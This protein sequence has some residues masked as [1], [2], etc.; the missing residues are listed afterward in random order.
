MAL[1]LGR[2]FVITKGGGH[3]ATGALTMATARPYV[4]RMDLSPEELTFVR[5]LVKTSRQRI[6]LVKWV[7]RDGT[8]RQTML[9]Q[10]EA[11]RLNAVAHRLAV[12]KGE[13]LRQ[14]AHIPNAK[15]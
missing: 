13:V 4:L 11:V 1:R 5:E 7:D 12:S 2:A 9:T 10:T 8:D 15:Q 6:H 3:W 14:A